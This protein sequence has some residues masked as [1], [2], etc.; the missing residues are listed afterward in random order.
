MFC[1][2]T[3]RISGQSLATA[4]CSIA[5]HATT[6]TREARARLRIEGEHGRERVRVA[7]FE[8]AQIDVTASNGRLT[9]ASSAM[10]EFLAAHAAVTNQRQTPLTVP[11]KHACRLGANKAG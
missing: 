2:E 11:S 4:S 9:V 10:E 6:V 8:S 1:S 3:T 7:G 5:G